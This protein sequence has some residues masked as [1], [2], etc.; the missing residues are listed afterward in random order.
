MNKCKKDGCGG[1]L[2]PK[3]YE[4]DGVYKVYF[5]CDLNGHLWH[6]QNTSVNWNDLVEVK[7]PLADVTP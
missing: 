4:E 1:K 2:Y 5:T 7:E 6:D 3:I